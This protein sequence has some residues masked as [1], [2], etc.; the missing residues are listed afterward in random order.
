MIK[1]EEIDGVVLEKICQYFH[2]KLKFT[3]T[4][5]PQVL[6]SST[7]ALRDSLAVLFSDPGVHDRAGDCAGVADGV[8]LPGCV[9]AMA[10]RPFA[11]KK[12][13][14]TRAQRAALLAISA[15]VLCT[16]ICHRAGSSK[17]WPWVAGG[18]RSACAPELP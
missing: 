16:R 4:Q 13:L 6:N 17:C 14:A 3:N 7:A 11:I 5:Q 1:F 10:R 12:E 8:Q 15:I 18:I 2:Y 9:G